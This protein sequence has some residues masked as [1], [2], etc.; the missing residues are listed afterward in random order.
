MAIESYSSLGDE[1]PGLQ[2]AVS[3]TIDAAPFLLGGT[4]GTS[5]IE[6]RIRAGDAKP[7]G[8]LITAGEAANEIAPPDYG[9]G[10]R[11]HFHVIQALAD[12]GAI[13]A[14]WLDDTENSLAE[15]VIGAGTSVSLASLLIVPDLAIY[16]SDSSFDGAA[17]DQARRHFVGIVAS[18]VPRDGLPI[19]L[20][21]AAGGILEGR[22]FECGEAAGLFRFIHGLGHDA[23]LALLA[24][25]VGTLRLSGGQDR[26]LHPLIVDLCE[27]VFRI[28]S[29]PVERQPRLG[30][31]LEGFIE[32]AV[33]VESAGLLLKGW[34]LHGAEDRVTS[35]SVV[36][37]FGRRCAIALPLAP[38]MRPDVVK[39]YAEKVPGGRP[40]SGFLA[41]VP[42]DDLSSTES[43][44][45]LEVTTDS[46]AL[47][48]SPFRLGAR[49]A[50]RAGV[51]LCLDLM[52]EAKADLV[53]QF[54]R[55]VGPALVHYW[56]AGHVRTPDISETVF[57]PQP[58]APALSVIVPLY[59]RIDFVKHQI[60]AFSNDQAF[61]SGA[62]AHELIYVLDDPGKSE[63]L[64]RL[65]RRCFEAYGV[66][67]RILDPKANFGYSTANNLGAAHA[68]GK[69]LLL[70]NS[71]VI[72]KASGW[73]ADLLARY[74]ALP[75]CG[76]LGCR[77]LLDDGG[78]QHAGID[79]LPCATLPGAFVNTHPAKGLPVSFD[80]HIGPSIVP[81]VTG[82]CLLIDRALYLRVGGLST[83]F[84]IGDF[85]DSDLC[86]KVRATGLDVY[87][88]PEVELYHLERQSF[89][90]VA[91]GAAER[92]QALTYYNM[93]LHAKKWGDVITQL[94]ASRTGGPMRSEAEASVRS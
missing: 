48:R 71:D 92:R 59:G 15:I 42:V 38:V 9:A 81:A 17:R 70:L 78:L 91:E 4:R 41:F 63:D 24:R 12:Q 86:L 23:K 64:A 29:E 32:V 76:V 28:L 74:G 18:A 22:A 40:D 14:G 65:A 10:A 68:R 69:H 8:L 11:L 13:V 87:Y 36:S 37:F 5:S 7:H 72:P 52:G 93:W 20:S 50:S 73:S 27:T 75:N 46:G 19:R 16:A 94:I 3:E 2:K 51:D 55:G 88:T 77:L 56:Q 25:L 33:P 67:F 60:A 35:A 53:P 39:A 79:F 44:W 85:E 62:G 47:L 45:F 58:E 57:G 6:R 83:D 89:G 43:Y 30:R 34:V 49:P 84:V 26:P 90:V 80:P 21:D 1:T 54:E 66:S 82:A 31:P 61:Q